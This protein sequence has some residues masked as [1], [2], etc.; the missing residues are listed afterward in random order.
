MNTTEAQ[1][2]PPEYAQAYK[3]AGYWK[4]ETFSQYL[5]NICHIYATNEAVVARAA[6]GTHHRLTYAQLDTYAQECI[7]EY[8]KAG[9]KAG[10]RVILH[11]PN[12]VEYMGAMVGAFL[13]GLIPIF[14]LIRHTADN[15]AAFVDTAQAQAI[16]TVPRFILTNYEEKLATVSTLASS[17]FTPIFIH[18]PHADNPK[19]QQ[20]TT[21]EEEPQCTGHYTAPGNSEDLAL[22][23]LS[24]GTT[25]IPK[26]I[27]RTHD[28]YLYSVRAS[29]DI[30]QLTAED[31]MLLTIPASHNYAMSSPGILGIM[32]AG[33]CV[34]LNIDPTP[35]TLL[36]LSKEEKITLI[37]LVPPLLMSLLNSADENTP[38]QLESVRYIQV[39]GAKLAPNAATRV[40]EELGTDLQQVFGMAEGLVCYTRLDDPHELC[41]RT[42]GRP[43]SPADE[44]R[45]LDDEGIEVEPG[46]PGNLWVR[47]P[48]TIRGY[49]NSTAHPFSEDGFYCSGDI[50]RQLESGHL[51]VDGR[52]KD[53][54]NRAGEKVSAEELENHLITLPHVR[55]AVAVG[56]P[57]E[58]LGEK[59]IVFFLSD[60]H[61]ELAQVRTF[62]K[63]RGVPDFQ[64][65][66]EVR[67]LDTFP[68]TAVGK[69]SRKELRSI[70]N[71]L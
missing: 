53:H 1:F 28:D 62:L 16:I 23:Q 39:G 61:Y 11:L 52:A 22:I 30:C 55:D 10:D 38:A 48:Y 14:S 37:P 32:H 54:I 71:E 3:E 45:V 56:A 29:A 67:F 51:I 31:R 66:D 18:P 42:Q 4:G 44:I 25:G 20:D 50:V 27:P 47:G 49:L 6:N 24:G 34:V 2:Y 41:T 19:P 70:L 12:T 15:L 21:H 60:H 69:I 33:G 8:E 9:L 43:I 26:L 35:S 13:A 46:Q 7:R 64:F 59:I 63:E 58:I 5:H 65:P 57:D 40:Y 17:S 36:N 68:S